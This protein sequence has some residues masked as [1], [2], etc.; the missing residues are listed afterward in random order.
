MESDPKNAANAPQ[1][2]PPLAQ[3]VAAPL[4]RAAIF[5]I[6]TLKS[7]PQARATVR[8][9]CGDLSGIFRA[10]EMRDLEAGLSCIVSIGSDAW[11]RLFGSPRPAMLHPFREIR[12]EKHTGVAAPGGFFFHIPAQRMGLC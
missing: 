12:G 11:D 6:V 5:L 3:P 2:V 4:S 1:G 10:V 8:S 7:E 9:F